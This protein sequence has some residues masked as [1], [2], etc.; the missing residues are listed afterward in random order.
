VKSLPKREEKKRSMEEPFGKFRRER[1]R[2]QVRFVGGE[3]EVL[4]EQRN[5]ILYRRSI[6]RTFCRGQE[7]RSLY[8]S[9]IAQ[10]IYGVYTALIL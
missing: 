6:E 4:I 1:K 5:I 3:R 8:D 7:A 10:R 2:T 9:M